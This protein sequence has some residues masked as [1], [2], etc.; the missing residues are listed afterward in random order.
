MYFVDIRL[1]LVLM[2]LGGLACETPALQPPTSPPPRETSAARPIPPAP[3]CKAS[4]PGAPSDAKLV[5]KQAGEEIKRCFLLG[6]A[7]S[8]PRAV[9]VDLS[10]REDGSVVSK[11]S[12][13]D[14]AEAG[15]LVC[16]EGVLSK[17]QFSKFCR[18][19]VVL[20]WNYSL[21]Q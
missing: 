17:L 4:D 12:H 5:M 10:I 8:T 11:K 7:T 19:N 1:G 14:G 15:Q 9:A 3:R 18:D 20:S 2:M 16:A 13:A 21:T 6:K